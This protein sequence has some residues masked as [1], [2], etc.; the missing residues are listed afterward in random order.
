MKKNIPHILNI[1]T[2]LSFIMLTT[3]V[4]I[5]IRTKHQV[6]LSAQKVGKQLIEQAQSI[7]KEKLQTTTL[8]NTK[9]ANS[10]IE[11]LP[12]ESLGYAY[13]LANDGT[14][15]AHPI[16]KYVAQKRTIFTIAQKFNNH[17]LTVIA[18]RAL[19]KHEG[20]ES[21]IDPI[22]NEP[23][24]VIYTPIADTG[25]ALILNLLKD[26]LFADYEATFRHYKITILLTLILFLILLWIIISKAYDC[27]SFK[28]WHTSIFSTCMFIIG[29]GYLWQLT[30]Q[31]DI[32]PNERGTI[33]LNQKNATDFIETYNQKLITQNPNDPITILT[34]P[35]G[36]VIHNFLFT[37]PNQY[38]LFFQAWQKFPDTLQPSDATLYFPD[39]MDTQ[40]I[41]KT[42][43]LTNPQKSV[44]YSCVVE[45][46][47]QLMYRQFPLDYQHLKIR[48]QPLKGTQEIK[49]TYQLLIPD[50]AAYPLI[51]PQF[52]PG[53]ASI[54]HINGWYVEN[55]FFSYDFVDYHSERSQESGLTKHPE[56]YFN[57]LIKRHP[58]NAFI[59]YILPLLIALVILF[60]ILLLSSSEKLN[61]SLLTISGLSFPIIITHIALRDK[62]PDQPIFYLE[63][64]FIITY[65][66]LILLLIDVATSTTTTRIPFLKFRQ[67]ILSKI[68]YWPLLTGLGLLVTAWTFY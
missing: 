41:I 48:I 61:T 29:I 54:F 32:T 25:Q 51:A 5:F 23:S 42:L 7:L 38:K 40:T 6:T 63:Y 9:D 33:L 59:V 12:L 43:Q 46:H 2:I 4:F 22:T 49:H 34:I 45:I 1:L 30:Y 11:A 39:G 55:S 53:L 8:L 66:I 36:I 57:I 16:E 13:I 27:T 10:I 28:L 52:K 58:L 31:I 65:F 24:L 21:I 62:I 17:T 44:E 19:A 15:L 26:K 35:T 67:N 56:L 18:H 68:L 64:F 14:F 20:I 37:G 60:L 3:L 47:Q 50:L